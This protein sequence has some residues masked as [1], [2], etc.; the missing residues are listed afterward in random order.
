M[1]L[2]VAQTGRSL[3]GRLQ[4]PGDKSLTHRALILGTLAQGDSHFEAPLDAAD[5]RATLAVMNAL[6]GQAR[7][8]GGQLAVKGL[9]LHGLKP[10]QQVLDCGNSGTAMRLL[11]G[12]LAAQPF[13]SSLTGDESLR[14]RPMN[15]I[16]EPLR[17][18]GAQIAGHEGL[19]P[20]RIHPADG[21]LQAAVYELPIASA[22]VKSCLMLA[23]LYADGETCLSE[24]GLS[25]DHTER[26][27]SAMGVAMDYGKGRLRMQ[28]P[29]AGGLQPLKGRIPADPSSAAFTAAAAALIPGSRVVLENVGLNPT[30]SALFEALTRMGFDVAVEQRPEQLGEPVAQLEI[31]GAT[32]DRQGCAGIDLAPAWVPRMIDEL[33]LL[34]AVATQVPGITRIRQAAELRHKESDRIEAMGAGLRRLGAEV[35]EYADGID[36]SGGELHSA[37]VDARGDHR[38]AMSFAVLG[39]CVP[40]GVEIRDVDNI[41]TSYPEFVSHLKALGAELEMRDD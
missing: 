26:M 35:T 29:P 38:I 2:R 10:P 8:D 41:V 21:K 27:L 31:K 24:P 36:V 5:T 7:M 33:P 9:G 40:G 4:P 32:P 3:S 34:M 39:L 11:A 25:R 14:Q 15:R 16:I 23:G 28:P 22:Q 37:L 17:R 1:R 20:L 13:A 18:M 12:V 30:R 19:P 6:G